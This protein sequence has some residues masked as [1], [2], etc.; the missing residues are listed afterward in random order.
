MSDNDRYDYS[1][2]YR[3]RR[4]RWVERGRWW[5][6]AVLAAVIAAGMIWLVASSGSLAVGNDRLNDPAW[7]RN[8]VS[9]LST[10]LED[11]DLAAAAQAD[12][13]S[14]VPT[15]DKVAFITIDDGYTQVGPAY[16]GAYALASEYVRANNVPVT[17]FLTYYAAQGH[18]SDFKQWGLRAELGNHA[19]NHVHL[20]TEDAVEQGRQITL[21]RDWLKR[22]LGIAPLLF[23][24]PYGEHNQ[25]TREQA[26]AAGYSHI[27]RWTSAYHNGVRTEGPAPA[28]GSILL[29][30]FEG[31]LYSNLVAMMTEIEAAGLKPALLGDYVFQRT[32][33]PYA[34]PARRLP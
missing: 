30:H 10:E 13:W 2:V 31:D 8:G 28:A 16:Q 1:R 6:I 27:I 5:P 22:D 20:P 17:M 9:T 14:V 15:T 34:L 25:V 29:A 4:R 21:C 32:H 11:Y 7:E 24:P 19:K 26:F 3:A 33:R 12:V 18:L 23:R